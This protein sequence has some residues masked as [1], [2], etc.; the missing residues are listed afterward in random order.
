MNE[1][2]VNYWAVLVCGVASQILGMLWYSPMLF[3]RAWMKII[4]MADMS[5][6]ATKEMKKKAMPGY[7][8]SFIGALVMAYVLKHFLAYAGAKDAVGGLQGAFWAWLGFVGTVGLT[9]AMFDVRPKKFFL[10]NSGFFLALLLIMGA[11]L[12]AWQ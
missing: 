8:V 4:G 5:P 10:I 9:N 12:G 3:G 2:V 1:V 6:E 7:L 11:I